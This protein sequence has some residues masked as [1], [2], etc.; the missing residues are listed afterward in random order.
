MNTNKQTGRRLRPMTA[1]NPTV[2]HMAELVTVDGVSLAWVSL[3]GVPMNVEVT[4]RRLDKHNE[5]TGLGD[6]RSCA[7]H[8]GMVPLHPN[9]RALAENLRY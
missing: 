2:Q 8:I 1:T 7:T 9:L 5:H 3:C 6:C 4:I